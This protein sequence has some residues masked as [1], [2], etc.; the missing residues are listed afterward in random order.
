MIARN[1][2]LISTPHILFLWF[3]DRRN[4]FAHAIETSPDWVLLGVS[5]GEFSY[6]LDGKNGM[7]RD[8]DFILCPPG[9]SLGRK[10][11]NLADFYVIR[12]RWKQVEPTAWSGKWT[13]RDGARLDSNLKYLRRCR[14][15]VN[16]A[17]R[18]SWA[19]HLLA[20]V[21]FQLNNEMCVAATKD[22]LPERLILQVE[23][24]FR[25]DIT[26]TI[27][28]EDVARRMGISPFQLSRRFRK[29]FGI[30]PSIYRARLRIQHAREL[31]LGTNWTTDRIAEA[32]G[33]ENAF[34]FSRVFSRLVGRSPRDFRREHC[35]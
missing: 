21:L 10:I 9:A 14:D 12:F 3:G 4:A 8:G 28:L 13:L 29:V 6:S 16:D 33:F 5:R 19:N 2:R 31:L 15:A 27:T 30:S 7:C 18:S 11:I 26:S 35:I 23:T 32:C 25:R 34:Y 17:G 24:M 20:D 1:T 22:N